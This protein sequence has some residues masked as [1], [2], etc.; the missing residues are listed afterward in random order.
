M[1]AESTLEYAQPL[2]LSR[3][4]EF[5]ASYSTQAT[6]TVSDAAGESL[7]PQSVSIGILLSFAITA[8]AVCSSLACG[9]CLQLGTNL[10]IT[11]NSG[12]I[13]LIFEKSLRLSPAARA[14][15]ATAGEIQNHMS[16]DAESIQ[17]AITFLPLMISTPCEITAG[18]YLLYRQL[19]LSALAGLAVVLLMTPIQ[20]LLAR[21]LNRTSKQKL[22]SMD[23]RILVL[24]ETLL[25]IKVIKLYH[26]VGPLQEKITKLRGSELKYLRRMGTVMAF[27]SIMATSVPT[28]MALLSFTVFVLVGG[29]GINGSGRG[30][31]NVQVVFVSM[32]LFGRLAIPIGRASTILG[33]VIALNVAAK[34]IQRF[35]LSEE[36]DPPAIEY[37]GEQDSEK[38][39]NGQENVTVR[40]QDGSFSW[41]RRARDNEPGDELQERRDVKQVRETLEKEE[42]SSSTAIQELQDINLTLLRGSLT[43]IVGRVGQGKSSLLSA[44]IGEMYKLSGHVVISGRIAYVPQQ[45]WI[46]NASVKENIIFGKPFDRVKYNRIIVASGLTPD[47]ELLPNGAETEIGERGINLSGGQK[48]RISLARAAYQDADV[49][50]LDDPLSAVDAHVE[51]HLWQYLLGPTG[52]LKHKTRLLVTHNIHRLNE[53]NQIVVIKNGTI[54]ETGQYQ[55]LVDEEEAFA[56]SAAT[57][58]AKDQAEKSE[59]DKTND[60]SMDAPNLD[61]NLKS[62]VEG[63]HLTQEEEVAIRGA[64][65]RAFWSYTKAS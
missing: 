27:M 36:I 49:Y 65:L 58:D 5:M 19:G 3:L 55:D 46:I 1:L 9:Q 17:T 2:L 53:A 42:S 13:S 30:D 23:S 63:G 52:L 39:N 16:V 48:Q 35:L 29:N 24:T 56:P 6:M 59:V 4:L 22:K 43:M 21:L 31:L 40:I 32:S 37:V 26:W 62:D 44:I 41:L 60:D 61:R 57:G 18:L 51:Q 64:G 25:G 45:A 11:L 47:I 38:Q 33:Q 10:G 14:T 34:R 28:L 54:N 7:R 12:L 20:G 15:T 50:L 8:A